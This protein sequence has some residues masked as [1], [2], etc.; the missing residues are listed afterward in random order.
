MNVAVEAVFL[1]HIQSLV[2][3]EGCRAQVLEFL[4]RN[5]YLLAILKLLRNVIPR[6]HSLRELLHELKYY[7]TLLAVL[8]EVFPEALHL[9][10]E[11]LFLPATPLPQSKLTVVSNQHIREPIPV[12]LHLQLLP[13][14]FIPIW[15]SLD[16]LPH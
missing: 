14:L 2:E 3:E 11:L 16:P 8:V 5:A 10:P 7:R 4:W 9:L 13:S 12:D 6:F 1:R 15:L